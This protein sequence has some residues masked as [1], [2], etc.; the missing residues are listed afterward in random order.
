ME[1]EEDGYVQHQV[2]QPVRTPMPG[3]LGDAP[4]VVVFQLH[5]QPFHHLSGGPAGLPATETPPRPARTD[6]SAGHQDGHQIAWQQRLLRLEL[7]SQLVMIAA[8]A[9]LCGHT[10][11]TCTNKPKITNYSCRISA[12]VTMEMTDCRAMAS[13]AQRDSGITSVGLNADALVNAR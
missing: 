4:A 9:P 2:L 8:A 11:L 13:F 5:Q 10:S 1:R 12:T 6:L 3:R 7:V